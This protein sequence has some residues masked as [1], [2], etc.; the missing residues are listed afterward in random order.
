MQRTSDGY[1][2]AASALNYRRVTAT[3]EPTLSWNIN[4]QAPAWNRVISKIQSFRSFKDDWDGEG[5]LAPKKELIDHIV[6]RAT[7]F[8]K[9][10]FNVPSRILITDEG[11]VAIEWL[12]P[13]G[14]SGV[15]I[16]PDYVDAYGKSSEVVRLICEDLHS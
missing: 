14:I 1:T 13:H 10:E 6:S 5:S 2:S 16:A 12:E 3:A 4:D 7:S 11:A 8:W 9:F 15:E